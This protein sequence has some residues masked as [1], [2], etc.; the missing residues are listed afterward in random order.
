MQRSTPQRKMMFCGL[1]IALCLLSQSLV[2]YS[3]GQV[4]T[5]REQAKLV[6]CDH[7]E[8]N[9]L[10][11]KDT[12]ELFRLTR[13]HFT[14]ELWQ[15]VVVP[16]CSLPA[17]FPAARSYSSHQILCEFARRDLAGVLLS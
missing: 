5:G 10:S 13:R 7:V 12:A 4:N 8:L 17:S 11:V 16:K 6:A 1:L 15:A 9:S 14:D 2:W 3:A